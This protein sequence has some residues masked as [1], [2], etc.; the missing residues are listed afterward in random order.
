MSLY[1]ATPY[2]AL[3][4]HPISSILYNGPSLFVLAFRA[5]QLTLS[6]GPMT[7]GYV[8]LFLARAS[9]LLHAWIFALPLPGC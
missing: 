3:L 6:A 1:P 8:C 9:F 2:R 5:G 4:H 7:F